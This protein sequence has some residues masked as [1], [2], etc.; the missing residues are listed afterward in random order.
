MQYGYLESTHGLKQTLEWCMVFRTQDQ[1]VLQNVEVWTV[2]NTP[3]PP[4]P[5]NTPESFYLFSSFVYIFVWRDASHLMAELI[6]PPVN[7]ICQK[8]GRHAKKHFS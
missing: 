7:C 2:H 8:Q 1:K 6:T 3:P 4:C 5:T